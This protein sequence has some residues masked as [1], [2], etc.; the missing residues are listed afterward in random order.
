MILGGDELGRTQGGNNNGY[1]QDGPVSWVAWDGAVRDRELT[2][3]VARLCRLRREHP[4]FRRRQFF[5][6]G[7]AGPYGRRDLG[8]FR[9]DGEAMTAADWG[10]GFARALV[11]A[12]SGASDDGAADDDSFLLLI[13]AWWEPLP[14]QLPALAR[15]MTWDVAVDTADVAVGGEEGE[16][17]VDPA[18]GLEVGPRSLLLL[19][20]GPATG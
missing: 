8:W 17:R 12:L 4:V 6:G 19:R 5:R 7:P 2:E 20:S 15:S 3:F 16:R 13:N 11:V 14:V 10:A 9:P 18:A 1:C